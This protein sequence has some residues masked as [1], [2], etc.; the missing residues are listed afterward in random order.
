MKRFIPFFLGITMCFLAYTSYAH[1]PIKICDFR[2]N[3]SSS[4]SVCNPTAAELTDNNDC[5]GTVKA[6][7]RV[8]NLATNPV[9][10]QTYSLPA[11]T[12]PMYYEYTVDGVTNVIGPITT[13]TYN[14]DYKDAQK[15]LHPIYEYTHDM[16]F[17]LDGHCK[18][19]QATNIFFDVRIIDDNGNLW[20]LYGY[21]DI[22]EIFTCAIFEETCNYCDPLCA[23]S[24]LDYPGLL[25]CGEPCHGC[26]STTRTQTEKVKLHQ[27]SDGDKYAEINEMIESS[28]KEMQIAPNPFNNEI[29]LSFPS[30]ADSEVVIQIINAEGKME[31]SIQA[32]LNTEKT[33][34]LDL[35][36]LTNGIYYCKVQ[37][38]KNV[39]TRKI[40]KI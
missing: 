20:D 40:I 24:T 32:V 35:T 12:P 23:G 21:G 19:P 16:I 29:T 36:D 11:G 31:R 2:H 9:L 14:Y 1:V 3:L 7:L 5:T 37:T 25:A 28:I 34:R 33:I 38:G 15:N 6:Y 26:Q 10:G 18:A 22:G 27:V 8:A 39:E 4:Q 17:S 13:F 30:Y